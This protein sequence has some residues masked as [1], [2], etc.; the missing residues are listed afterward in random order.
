MSR[1]GKRFKD[2]NICLESLKKEI[3][4]QNLSSALEHYLAKKNF[5]L[6]NS[7]LVMKSAHV[8]K[9]NNVYQMEMESWNKI[10]LKASE[11]I[12]E[13]YLLMRSMGE[14]DNEMLEKLQTL[15][16]MLQGQRSVKFAEDQID[17]ST[18]ANSNPDA[19]E[20]L[21][22]Q[23]TDIS[24][25]EEVVE[26][27]IS[28]K[29]RANDESEMEKD[30]KKSKNSCAPSDN[31]QFLRPKALKSINFD[32]VPSLPMV[33]GDHDLNIT[34][35]LN[36]AGPSSALAERTNKT[37]LA[38]SSTALAVAKGNKK[39]KVFFIQSVA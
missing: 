36:P 15:R 9:I 7:K 37:T 14:L 33:N 6:E 27:P 23:I 39:G 13:N 1:W 8:N 26:S 38:S 19:V 30:S 18:T 11:V 34:F 12:Q 2:A 16:K 10:G 35:D 25:S 24:D 28:A 5:E 21:T 20:H 3:V 17:V 31:F 29:K 22:Y 4:E 32:A